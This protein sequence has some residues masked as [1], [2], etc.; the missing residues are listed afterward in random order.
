MLERADDLSTM[1][2]HLFYA[3]LAQHVDSQVMAIYANDDITWH[4]LGDGCAQQAPR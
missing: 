1:G 2:D 3:H 4:F